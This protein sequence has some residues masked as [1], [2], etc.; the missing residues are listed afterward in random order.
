MSS[1][2]KTKKQE[3]NEENIRRAIEIMNFV[4]SDIAAPRNI[5][6]FVKDAIDLLGKKDTS[7]GM[8]SATAIQMLDEASQD[9]NV[10]ML[11]RTRIW[12]ALSILE[13]V[14]D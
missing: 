6:N 11:S 4:V 3:I 14:K 5:R 1:R 2:Q 8:R 7:P 10:P 13:S 9:T 12:S